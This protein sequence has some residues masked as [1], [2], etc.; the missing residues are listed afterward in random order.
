M[1]HGAIVAGEVSS[2]HKS[3]SQIGLQPNEYLHEQLS[4]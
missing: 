4:N 3:K 1:L 2:Y